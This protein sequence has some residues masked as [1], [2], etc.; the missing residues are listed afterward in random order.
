MTEFLIQ[1]SANET[2]ANEVAEIL[3]NP[4]FGVYRTDHMVMAKWSNGNWHDFQVVPFED[5]KIDPRAMALHYGQ[6]IFEGLKAFAGD[7]GKITMFRPNAN[8]ARMQVSAER[9]AMPTLPVED[10]VEACDQLV[11]IDQRWVPSTPGTSLYIRP[12][13]FATEAHIGVRSAHEFHFMVIAL[14]VAP[15]FSAGFEPISLAVLDEFTRAAKGGTGEAK[16]AG[17]YAASLLAKQH[18]KDMGCSEVLWLDAAEHKYIEELSGMNVFFVEETANGPRLITPNL[19][20][21]I[22]HGITRDSLMQLAPVLDIETEERDITIDEIETRAAKGEITEA[23]ACGTAAVI[24]PISDLKFEGGKTVTFG[25]GKPG[26][27]T[28]RLYEELIAIQQGHSALFPEWRH[29]VEG[30]SAN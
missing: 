28:T 9:M 23:F 4:G 22:L 1:R 27:T 14:P 16:C 3:A 24:A 18:A 19:N 10:F 15:F 5:L 25:N 2:P 6:E 8:A 30:A 13:M 21:T 7:N 17:N 29:V 12:Y 20:G 26:K 11:R